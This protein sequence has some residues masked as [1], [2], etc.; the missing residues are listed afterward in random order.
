A[1]NRDPFEVGI[2]TDDGAAIP[3]EPDVEFEAVAAVSYRLVERRQGIFRD[4]LESTRPAVA[5]KQRTIHA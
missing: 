1:R 5:E 2:V 3:R 4:R